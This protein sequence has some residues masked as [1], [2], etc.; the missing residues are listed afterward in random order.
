MEY[1]KERDTFKCYH[2]LKTFMNKKSFLWYGCIPSWKPNIL[3]RKCAYKVQY[4]I[5]KM[6]KAMKENKI[7]SKNPQR[8]P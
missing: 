6:K 3:C 2:C 4:G 5:K 8:E 1:Y 7:E